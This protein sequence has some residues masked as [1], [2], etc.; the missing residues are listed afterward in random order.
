M[1]VLIMLANYTRK[2]SEGS[3]IIGVTNGHSV[4]TSSSFILGDLMIYDCYTEKRKLRTLV[5][6]FDAGFKPESTFK[7]K[8]LPQEYHN[9]L[10]YLSVP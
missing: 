4:S 3:G 6:E 9:E 7:L 1:I 10:N 5:S 8:Y 2:W